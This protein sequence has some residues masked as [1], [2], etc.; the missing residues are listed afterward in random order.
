MTS[1]EK[2]RSLGFHADL[3]ERLL[4]QVN[5]GHLPEHCLFQL[6]TTFDDQAVFRHFDLIGLRDSLLTAVHVDELADGVRWYL[7]LIHVRQITG[8][9]LG[10]ASVPSRM[11]PEEEVVLP[12]QQMEAVL[13]GLTVVLSFATHRSIAME[14]MHCD[15]PD[16]MA[17]HGMIGSQK[18]DGLVMSFG[19]QPES[20]G[21]DDAMTFVGA[22]SMRLGEQ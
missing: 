5:A 8:L 22:L 14:P 11:L 15:D 21:E 1:F 17:D 12:G 10:S 16:C 9:E 6:E 20:S 4:R 7:N 13:P 3:I 19:V 18:D 2:V